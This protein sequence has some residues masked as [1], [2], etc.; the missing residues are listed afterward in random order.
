[1]RTL[2]FIVTG[3]N[4]T[5]DPSCDYTGLVAGSVGYLRAEFR[6]DAA[7]NGCK[8]AASFWRGKT[9]HAVAVARGACIIPA[10]ALTRE[11]FGVSLTGA[12]AGYRI[13]TNKIFVHQEV[14]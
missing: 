12:R 14:G 9:E 2:K 11:M 10:E 5:L 7:W 8:V 4:I 1:M 13:N 6:T 3:Q